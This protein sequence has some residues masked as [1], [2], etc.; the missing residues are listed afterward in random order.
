MTNFH[1][2]A[3]PHE[4]LAGDRF[5]RL[6]EVE[7]ITGVRKS[8]IYALQAQTPPAFPRSVRVSPRSVAWPLSAINQWMDERKQ[9]GLPGAGAASKQP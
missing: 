8:T 6:P 3:A 9:S 1:Q 4:V 2:G 7:R 5:L